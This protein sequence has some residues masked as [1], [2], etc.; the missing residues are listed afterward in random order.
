MS[1]KDITVVGIKRFSY[2]GKVYDLN[3]ENEHNYVVS[4]VSVHNSAA[5]SEVCYLLDI[6]K[7]DPLKNKL[8]FE[9]FLNPA[10]F[11]MPDIDCDIATTPPD[12]FR[13]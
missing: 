12:E 3:V 7:I 11:N 10:R 1:Q 6:T 13:K 2:K 5:G 9:R 8:M 4:D